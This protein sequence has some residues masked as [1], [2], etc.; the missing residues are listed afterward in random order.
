M[1]HKQTKNSYLVQSGTAPLRENNHVIDNQKETELY[2]DLIKRKH[3]ICE[4]YIITNSEDNFKDFGDDEDTSMPFHKRINHFDGMNDEEIKFFNPTLQ[5]EL[6]SCNYRLSL[7][8]A[9][10]D[11]LVD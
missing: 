8:K 6:L 1:N 2:K 10:H 7:H 5:G 4:S 9:L 11:Y 3:I